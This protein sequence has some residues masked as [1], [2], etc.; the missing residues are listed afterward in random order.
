MTNPG[1]NLADAAAAVAVLGCCP[2]DIDRLDDDSLVA[3]MRLVAELKSAIQPYELWLAGAIAKR[4]T[5]E[6]GYAGLARRNGAATPAVFIQSLT[7]SSMVEATKLANLGAMVAEES[8][9]GSGQPVSPVSTAAASGAITLD[10]AEAIRKGLGRPDAAVTAEQLQALSE[11]LVADAPGVPVETLVRMARQARAEL[12]AAA[13][14]RGEKERAAARYVR[15]Y[16]SDGM[17]GGSW[18]LTAEDGGLEIH[19]ALKLLVANSTDGP[20]F[21]ATPP[22]SQA[23]GE[24]PG[25]TPVPPP[26]EERTLD[27][28]LAD[29]FTQIFLN[30]LHVDPTIIPGAGRAPV[31]VIVEAKTLDAGT[32]VGL[33]EDN[34]SPVSFAKLEEYLCAGGT[35]EVVVG[36][37]G[38]IL[39]FGREQ[40]LYT[41]KQ[42]QALAVRDAGC[43]YPGC[44]KPASWCE[45]HHILQWKRDHGPTTLDNGI[46]LCRYHHMLIHNNGWHIHQADGTY[47]LTKPKSLDPDQVPIE[48]PSNNPI[49]TRIRQHNRERDLARTG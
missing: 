49:I 33:L 45:A 12:D 10:A 29:G 37:S 19:T 22:T 44:Q 27:Q 8:P 5:R 21:V 17:Y 31:R 48:M 30:G 18:R 24:T 15:L 3:G 6:A 20:R 9:D 23:A 4:S 25:P 16:E 2:D 14:E 39:N 11:C 35:V 46:L 38:D 36:D 42:R 34:L 26:T 28:I 41:P 43:R 47:W 7:G 32:G 1:L 40:R 13:V